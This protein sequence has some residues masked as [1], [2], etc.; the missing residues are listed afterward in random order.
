MEAVVDVSKT[1]TTKVKKGIIL[2]DSVV[3]RAE[4]RMGVDKG[5]A[6]FKI[7]G[8]EVANFSIMGGL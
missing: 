5:T 7:G 1:K 6:L 4:M 8:Y 3:L 2:S